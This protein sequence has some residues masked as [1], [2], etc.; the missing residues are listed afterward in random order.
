MKFSHAI[1]VA[2]LAV[3]PAD[4]IG[5]QATAPAGPPGWSWSL[6]RAARM[7]AGGKAIGTD[8]LFEFALMAPGWHLT[9]GPGGVVFDPR[10]KADHRYVLTAELILFPDASMD[11]EYG[12]F[13]GGMAL[14]SAADKQWYA[15]VVRGDGSAAVLHRAGPETHLVM[16][17]TKHAAVKPRPAD[18]TVTNVVQLRAEPDS[19]RFL[20]NGERITAFA[21]A[22]LNVNGPF[23]FRV[24]KGINLHIT[25]LD[26]TRRLA[27]FPSRSGAR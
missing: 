23:G 15:F 9:M 7:S 16:P 6:D 4:M 3:T 21:R 5:Q 27:P 10:E 26:V 19:I 2:L 14:E 13:V 24:G 22:D 18:A 12:I 8:S 17:W 1:V 25:N 20:V 11:A